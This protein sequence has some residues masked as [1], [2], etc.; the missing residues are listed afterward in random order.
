MMARLLIAGLFAACGAVVALDDCPGGD[1]QPLVALRDSGWDADDFTVLVAWREW[2]AAGVLVDAYRLEPKAGGEAFDVYIAQDGTTLSDTAARKLGIRPKHWDLAPAEIPLETPAAPPPETAPMRPARPAAVTA[3]AGVARASVAVPGIDRT[4]VLEEDA[5]QMAEGGLKSLVRIGV[6]VPL[7]EPLAITSGEP[8]VGAWHEADGLRVWAVELSAPDAVGLRLHLDTLQ[9]PSGANLSVY[10]AGQPYEAYGP[11]S[12]ADIEATAHWTPSCFGER[13]VLEV[14]VPA[15]SSTSEVTLAVDKVIYI[16][17]PLAEPALKSLV[18]AAVGSCNLDVTCYPSWQDEAAA[19]GKITVVLGLG[20]ALC[21]SALVADTYPGP[22]PPYLLTAFHCVDSPEKAASA[23]VYW[24]YQTSTCNG[25]VPNPATVPRTTGGADFLVGTDIYFGTDFALLRLRQAPP[26]YLPRLGW[27]GSE[28]AVH[29]PVVVIHHP[30]GE[31]KRISF[32]DKT[33]QSGL[34][35]SA[36]WSAGTTE[37]GSSGS[38][39]MRADTRQVVGVLSSGLARCGNQLPD[40]FGR[41]DKTWPLLVP[42]LGGDNDGDGL[43]D[44]KEISGAY[45]YILDPSTPDTDGDG[46]SD[47]DEI[48]GVHGPPTDPTNPDTDGDGLSDY[49]EIFGTHGPPTDPTNPDTDGDGLSDYDEVMGIR[50]FI[51]DPTMSDTDGDG[52]SDYEE[53]MGVHGDIT[54][55]ANP[56]TDDDGW[57]DYIEILLGQNPLDPSDAHEIPSLIPP[58]F[59]NGQ[60]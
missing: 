41:F 25:A 10:N 49:D 1:M 57:S 24:L 50:G 2:T 39:L 8:G 60:P 51:S 56:D 30:G 44:E 42:Y 18:T 40:E 36:V 7:A 38:P 48:F 16:Y 23:E 9:L 22:T 46:L 12:Q 32:G 33:K 31:H 28:V 59:H 19:V 54:D 11:F 27:S 53:V 37:P 20:L 43:L 26:A 47:Y 6:F 55:P 21:T 13:V 35:H 58:W 5:R 15:D 14:S 4:A 52:L 3:R 29:T 17:R 34:Y 45:G